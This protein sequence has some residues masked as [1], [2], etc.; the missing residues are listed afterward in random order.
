M[1]VHTP[2]ELFALRKLGY[3][4]PF[5]RWKYYYYYFIREWPLITIA[6][7]DCS[8]YVKAHWKLWLM[9]FR[10]KGI[11]MNDQVSTQM[12]EAHQLDIPEALQELKKEEDRDQAIAEKVFV[13][14]EA[15]VG[16]E[17]QRIN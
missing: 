9:W 16:K 7:K 6:P 12:A 11:K 13:Q 2:Q 14:T 4:Y 15:D 17:E 1:V 5:H 8:T 3:Y 10:K